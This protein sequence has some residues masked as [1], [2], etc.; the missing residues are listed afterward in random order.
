MV[1]EETRR[2]QAEG[3]LGEDSTPRECT[4]LVEAGG[5][6]G[7]VVVIEAIGEEESWVGLGVWGAASIRW[8][9]HFGVP[10]AAEEVEDRRL[11]VGVVH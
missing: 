9:Y 3:P 6:A 1:G 2:D 11:V 10:E 5:T 8:K 4:S 7:E